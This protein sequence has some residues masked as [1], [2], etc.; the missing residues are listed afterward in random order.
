M[1]SIEIHPEMQYVLDTSTISHIF[2]A[3]YRS[4]FPGFWERFDELVWNGCAVS[5]RHVRLELEN[6]KHPVVAQSTGYLE[7][8]KRDFFS[9]P[10]EQE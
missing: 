10:T 7:N 2:G 4:V 5:V 9:E 6:A 3:F 1:S 8:L